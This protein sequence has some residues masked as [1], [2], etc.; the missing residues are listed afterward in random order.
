V[1]KNYS[2]SLKMLNLTASKLTIVPF[3]IWGVD[4]APRYPVLPCLD[5]WWKG[6]GDEAW[7][8]H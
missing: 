5:Q 7:C 8:Y 2:K 6:G 4:S 1:Y 3:G